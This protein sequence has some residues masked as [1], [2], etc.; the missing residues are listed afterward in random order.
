MARARAARARPRHGARGR[1]SA[2]LEFAPFPDVAA[3]AA[4]AAPTRAALVVVSNW[5]CSLPDWLGPAGLL[6]HVDARRHLGR[7]RAWR[8]PAAR[9]SSARWSWPGARPGE[10]VHVGDSLENDVA[11]AR[12]AGHPRRCWSRATARR[13]PGSRRSA[14][15]PSCPPY[16]EARCR[17]R[18]RPRRR[19]R[20]CPRSARPRWPWWYGPLGFLAGADHRVHQRRDRVGGARRGRPGGLAGRDRG[21]APSCWTA[22]WWR[23]R[24]CSPRSCAG[25]APGTSACGRTRVLAGGG[26]G[27]ARDGRLL[28]VRGGL[29]GRSLDPDVEQTVAEDLGRGRA[30]PSA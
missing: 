27:G 5:D 2:S 4:R 10:A 26:L 24:C 7:G 8:S 9:S 6:E 12:A 15:S 13:R 14:R 23:R 28:R 30:A 20:S 18:S 29:L 16:S 19:R 1:C 21:R 25:R 3:R 17:P 11:G 22:R